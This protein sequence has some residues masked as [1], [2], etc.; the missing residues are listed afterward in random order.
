MK[1]KLIA[2]LIIGQLLF[3]VTQGGPIKK[4]P[5]ESFNVATNFSLVASV[6]TVTLQYIKAT[7]TRTHQDVTSTFVATAPAPGVFTTITVNGVS[8]TGMFVV[9]RLQGGSSL[10]QTLVDV[11]VTDNVTGEVF[12]A[13]FLVQVSSGLGG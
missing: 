3:A 11:V 4:T 13:Q 2:L 9:F 12:D 8:Q 1:K 5:T 6:D 7:D 10:Q